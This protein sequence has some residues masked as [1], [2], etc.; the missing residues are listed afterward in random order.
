MILFVK[1]DKRLCLFSNKTEYIQ[2]VQGFTTRGHGFFLW[3]ELQV[4]FTLWE[5]VTGYGHQVILSVFIWYW[6]AEL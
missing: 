2:I 3:E 6:D 5:E 4:I 1:K